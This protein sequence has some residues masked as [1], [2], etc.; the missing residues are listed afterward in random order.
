MIKLLVVTKRKKLKNSL[1]SVVAVL[2]TFIL[3][4]NQIH[5]QGNTTFVEGHHLAGVNIT[6]TTNTILPLKYKIDNRYA[7]LNIPGYNIPYSNGNIVMRGIM[8]EAAL[9]VDWWSLFGEPA[10]QYIFTWGAGDYYELVVPAAEGGSSIVKKISKSELRKYPDLLLRY[11]AI[12]PTDVSFQIEWS[13]TLT[14]GEVLD[15]T[16]YSFQTYYGTGNKFTTH[17]SS[18][19]ILTE[20]SGKIPF[21]VPGIRQGKGNKFLNLPDNFPE[22]KIKELMQVFV[23]SKQFYIS[24]VEIID[25]KWPVNEMLTI[26]E[27]FEKYEKG[28]ATPSPTQ[29][30]NTEINKLQNINEDKRNDFWSDAFIEDIK[31]IEITTDRTTN[32]YQIKVDNKITYQEE[33]SQTMLSKYSEKSKYAV[34]HDFVNKTYE[35]LNYKGIAQSINGQTKFNI[36]YQNNVYLYQNDYKRVRVLAKISGISG[37]GSDD[38]ESETIAINKLNSW[39][40]GYTRKENENKK[41]GKEIYRLSTYLSTRNSPYGVGSFIRYTTD[42]KLNVLQ[43]KVIYQ[44]FEENSFK[45]YKNSKQ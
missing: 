27:L 26:A 10:E 17:I 8:T 31:N 5:G 16:G 35:I 39:E 13:F 45:P 19:T 32:K 36:I 24:K 44:S 42:D 22:E 30:V 4:F 29:I 1:H 11:E 9:A 7:V 3:F 28:E 20:P 37:P 33:Q 2:F 12:K 18:A 25:I 23:K 14:D 38:Y 21:A 41:A 34:R 40:D 15:K 6:N 43:S